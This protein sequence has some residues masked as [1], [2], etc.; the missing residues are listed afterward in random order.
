MQDQVLHKLKHEWIIHIVYKSLVTAGRRSGE[1]LPAFGISEK[2]TVLDCVRSLVLIL[3]MSVLYN[4]LTPFDDP[5]FD[6]HIILLSPF[7]E[8]KQ[9]NEVQ[10]GQPSWRL[11][12]PGIVYDPDPGTF[13][14][15][16]FDILYTT[17]QYVYVLKSSS[18]L[19]KMTSQ[20]WKIKKGEFSNSNWL[21]L[22]QSL[23][24]I[25]CVHVENYSAFLVD[26]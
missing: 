6:F 5:P 7:Y 16:L 4:L 19:A 9:D 17:W 1:C 21:Q 25:K 14:G 8:F 2:T 15:G 20:N 10:L 3:K 24:F 13:L 23:N 12:D 26:P 11:L 18:S 22:F